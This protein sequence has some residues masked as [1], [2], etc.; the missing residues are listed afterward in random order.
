[1]VEGKWWAE[2]YAGPPLLAMS[3]DPARA[4]NIKIGD[5]VTLSILGREIVAKVAVI[6]RVDFGSFGASFPLVLTPSAI[7]GANP[8]HVAIAKATLAEEQRIF[9]S[10]GTTFPEVNIVSVREQLEAATELFDRVALAV[11]GAAA[12][13]LM[14]ALLVLASAIAA[15]A[16]ERTRE[17]AILRVLGASRAQVLSAYLLEYGLVGLISGAAG[18]A[19]GY[20]AAW[21]VVVR[22]FEAKW[23]VDWGGVFTLLAIASFLAGIGGLLAAFQSLSKRP[24]PALRSE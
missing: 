8:R 15:R 7:E 19:L 4:A 12:V 9:R 17:A 5:E 3:Q 14:A 13:A 23:S 18:V 11:R 2:N 6:R 22:V 21:P 10:L 20:A 24:A 16:V 1:V